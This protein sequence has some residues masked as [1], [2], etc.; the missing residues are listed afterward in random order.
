MLALSIVKINNI[1]TRPYIKL[2]VV[3]F[4]LFKFCGLF[5]LCR[6]EVL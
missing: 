6:E 3:C 2:L 1:F 5:D 4:H